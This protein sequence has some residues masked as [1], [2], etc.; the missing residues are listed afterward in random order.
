MNRLDYG[1]A[2]EDTVVERPNTR[3]RSSNKKRKWREIEAIQ[4]KQRLLKELQDIDCN[5][6]GDFDSLLM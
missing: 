4:E 6:D 1:S 2:L 3:S 5:F